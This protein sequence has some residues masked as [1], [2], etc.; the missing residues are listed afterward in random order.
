MRNDRPDDPSTSGLKQIIKFIAIIIKL[1]L[2]S[3]T[4]AKYVEEEAPRQHLDFIKVS[5][6]KLTFDFVNSFTCPRDGKLEQERINAQIIK[7][8]LRRLS[9]DILGIDGW[10]SLNVLPPVL[11]HHLTDPKKT[12]EPNGRQK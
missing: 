12:R 11:F 5:Y 8:V 9:K 1:H 4:L 7:T 2:F 10:L 6:E 3:V